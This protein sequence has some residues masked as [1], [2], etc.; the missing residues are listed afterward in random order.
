MLKYSFVYFQTTHSY[1][2]SGN[3]FMNL[4]ILSFVAIEPLA[5]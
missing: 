3:V 1:F 2:Y 4:F 5:V